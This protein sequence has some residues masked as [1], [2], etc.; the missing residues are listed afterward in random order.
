MADDFNKYLSVR[1]IS[2]KWGVTKNESCP[3]PGR[4]IEAS[5]IGR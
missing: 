2:K 4:K 5:K 1:D 3:D